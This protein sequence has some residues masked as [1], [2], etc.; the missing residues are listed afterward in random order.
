MLLPL[1]LK[2]LIL[3]L[4]SSLYKYCLDSGCG[5]VYLEV[6]PLQ[7]DAKDLINLLMYVYG[8]RE[9]SQ[10]SAVVKANHDYHHRYCIHH[11]HHHKAKKVKFSIPQHSEHER[12]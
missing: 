4:Y 5:G 10:Q 12:D 2:Y 7:A 9:K 6:Y 8:I 1:F 11:H 3:F